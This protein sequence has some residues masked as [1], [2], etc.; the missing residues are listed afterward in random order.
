MASNS[1]SETCSS[2]GRC[3]PAAKSAAA[4]KRLASYILP[5]PPPSPPPCSGIFLLFSGELGAEGAWSVTPWGHPASANKTKSRASCP[6]SSSPA[7][8]GGAYL[9]PATGSIKLASLFLTLP[10]SKSSQPP[11]T[12]RERPGSWAGPAGPPRASPAIP[13]AL[14]PPACDGKLGAEVCR[15]LADY[16]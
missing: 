6:F 10:T 11:G 16:C 8:T 4:A 13:R 3:S 9:V 12:A 15:P 1:A 5:P 2:V 14:G 7:P